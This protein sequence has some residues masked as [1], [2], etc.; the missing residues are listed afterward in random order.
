V[1]DAAG[2]LAEAV[3][4]LRRAAEEF[5]AHETEE[6]RSA[7]HRWEQ[8]RREFEAQAERRAAELTRD[9]DAARADRDGLAERH[10]RLTR[11]VA[12]LERRLASRGASADKLPVLG[13]DLARWSDP[14]LARLSGSGRRVT[15]PVSLVA[16]LTDDGAPGPAPDD[17]T[18]A[19][20]LVTALKRLNS[21]PDVRGRPFHTEVDEPRLEALI[22]R[23]REASALAERVTARVKRSRDNKS[24]IWHM[25]L[26]QRTAD[27][28]K[29][30]R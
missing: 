15:A 8:E 28:R 6:H 7:R 9:C 13:R 10:E 20:R 11:R 5:R 25:M 27:V 4:E 2:A 26:A 29:K 17:V 24:L 16:V 1:N 18:L 21:L 23:L 22:A 14:A 3:E 19:E 12:E 30:R